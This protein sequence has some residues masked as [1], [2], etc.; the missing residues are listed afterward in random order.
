[1]TE[2]AGLEDW[3][4]LPR[5]TE[6][7]N[8]MDWKVCILQGLRVRNQKE[9][10]PFRDL[11]TSYGNLQDQVASS[12]RETTRLEFQNNELEK[13]MMA[14]ERGGESS[15]PK[16]SETL[17]TKSK[18]RVEELQT[19]LVAKTEEL[20]EAQKTW[21]EVREALRKTEDEVQRKERRVSDL[22]DTQR[23]LEEDSE[24][25]KKLLKSS[26]KMNKDMIDEH[27]ALNTAFNALQKKL[28]GTEAENDTLRTKL[29]SIKA[30]DA[31]R[32]NEENE[33]F[34]EKRK[35]ALEDEIAQAAQEKPSPLHQGGAGGGSERRRHSSK[36]ERKTRKESSDSRSC[37]LAPPG[38]SIHP[39][40]KLHTVD[41]HD[42]EVSALCFSGD[43]NYMATGGAD[44]M[45]KVWTVSHD[46]VEAKY[47][48]QG[49]GASVMSVQFDQHSRMVLAGTNDYAARIWSLSSQQPKSIL[50][51]HSNKVMA[52]KF[53]EDNSKVVTGSHD[54]TLK[55]WDLQHKTC[56]KTLFAGS[57]CNDVVTGRGMGTT[58]ISGHFDKRIRFW[59]L[60]TTTANEIA[61]Q[62]KVT[63]LDHFPERHLLLC[64][65]RDDTLR[66]IDLRQNS[67]SATFSANGFH[68]SV[69]WTRACFSPDGQYVAAGSSD[70]T[71]FVWEVLTKAVKAH[72]EHSKDVVVCSWHPQ[73]H[74][75]ASGDRNKKVIIWKR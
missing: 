29:M 31:D 32:L 51:G 37:D 12:K 24:H 71:L 20:M 69:D 66:L 44:K 42:Q 43:G 11:V 49:C 21:M 39:T 64:C 41:A 60:R 19:K 1:M 27:D 23:K 48:L 58:M 65:S 36:D 9:S 22:Q 17:L 7:V 56:T 50:T 10:V 62:G 52:A 15:G 70:G 8:I 16:I 30:K 6:A 26:E 25:L 74:L 53:L 14:L 18:Q 3:F 57:S 67:I 38:P 13:Q 72:K 34:R 61:L 73:G 47:T 75:F 46:K 4:S 33:S 54:R 28:K 55:I 45:V 5:K 59:D 40:T 35:K 63:S 2:G 68:V